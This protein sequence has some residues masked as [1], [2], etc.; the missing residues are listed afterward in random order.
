MTSPS[1]RPA[2]VSLLLDTAFHNPDDF[3]TWTRKD[4]RPFTSEEF[5]LICSA[6]TSEL[7][8]FLDQADRE[9]D[10]WREQS[11]ASERLFQFVAP[12]FA[13]LPPGGT[14]DDLAALLTE[15]GLGEL[16][17]IA[18]VLAPGGIVVLPE[19]P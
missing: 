7:D 6:T 15:D 13:K 17:S 4:G 3:D 12:L 19:A 10:Y 18:E 14:I 9:L 2:V 1:I 16:N 11:E 8:A 5:D